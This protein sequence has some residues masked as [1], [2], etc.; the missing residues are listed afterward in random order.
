MS[1]NLRELLN[2]A[3]KNDKSANQ[4]LATI[5]DEQPEI[6]ALFFRRDE[7]KD[8]K[9]SDF[10][11][12]SDDIDVE[13]RCE[14]GKIETRIWLK[15][16]NGTLPRTFLVSELDIMVQGYFLNANSLQ[17]NMFYFLFMDQRL[18]VLKNL[19]QY[20]LYYDHALKLLKI[21]LKL[22]DDELDMANKL[23]KHS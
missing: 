8:S 16:R 19:N 12:H 15:S 17:R 4:L 13:F 18:A 23:I 7:V 14:G 9:P 22:D 3:L 5:C 21:D 10:E 6:L 20:L 2:L 11:W 1:A